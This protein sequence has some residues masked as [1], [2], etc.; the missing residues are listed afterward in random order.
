MKIAFTFPTNRNDLIN[1][2]KKG[3]TPDNALYGFNYIDK[4]DYV[5]ECEVNAYL[6][7]AFDFVLHPIN[8]LFISQIGIDFKLSRA[9]LMVRK[10]NKSDVI[11]SNIDG[12][13]LAICFLKKIGL[14]KPPIIYSVGLFYIQGKMVEVVNS[15]NNSLFLRFYKWILQ[16]SD[17]LLYHAEV[18]KEKLRNLELLDPS[19]TTFIAIGSDDKF[20]KIEQNKVTINIQSVVS[21]GKDRARDYKTLVRTARELPNL[22]FLIICRKSNIRGLVIPEN[23]K[24][25]FDVSY[26]KVRDLYKSAIMVVIPIKEMYRSSGQMTLTDCMQAGVPVVISKVV[27]ISHYPLVNNENCI[28]VT[29]GNINNLKK[30]IKSLVDDKSLR[31]KL[32]KNIKIISKQFTTKHYSDELRKTIIWSIDEN[33]LAPITKKDLSYLIKI[34]NENNKYFLTTGEITYKQQKEWYEAY[35]KKNITGSE[36]MYIL[37]INDK[38]C[39]TGAIYDIDYQKNRAKIGRFIIDR[40]LRGRGYGDNLLKK[41]TYIAF[42]KLNL[43]KIGLEVLASNKQA[44]KRYLKSGFKPY[45]KQTK[46]G[47]QIILMS[48]VKNN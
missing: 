44:I 34:R 2:A 13:S 31:Y 23:V 21:I 14:I 19:K 16:A 1:E 26:R 9:L 22:Q 39:G 6:E 46:K 42:E 38:N 47:K 24:L 40:D 7:R 28:L 32:K 10:L 5:F 4:K 37:K 45:K 18:E 3:L 12:M 29:P 8:K 30:A 15:K 43:E 36:Y 48:K 41:I 11:V 25:L 27:G 20:F 33:Q 17:Q 35:F